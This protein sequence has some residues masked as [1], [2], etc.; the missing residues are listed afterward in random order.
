M[1]R[2]RDATLG[3][4]FG[5]SNS[6]MA[7]RQGS[8]RAR[9]LALEGT[10]TGLPTALFFNTEDQRTHFGRDAIEQYLSGT[11][12]RLMRSLK[13][14]LGSALLQDKTVVHHSA[15][16]YQDIIALF[17]QMLA[18][19]A[20]SALGGL[21]ER[22]LLGRPVHFVDDNPERDQ[23]AQ[24]AL[25]QAAHDAG[26]GEVSFQ[27]EPIAAALDYEQRISQESLVL[28][29]DIGG[30]TSDFTVVR[31]GPQRAG[32]ADR[33]GDV[34]ATTGVHIGGTD[35]DRK[36]SQARVMPLLGLGH[37]G[38]H[39]REVPSKVFH[40]LS[41]WHLIQWLY[42]PQA[43]REAQALRSDYRQPALHARLMAVLQQRLG[44]RVAEAVEQAK[45]GVSAQGHAAPVRLEWLEPNL[46]AL[47]SPDEMEHDLQALLAQVVACARACLQLAGVPAQGRGVDAIY[48]TG[49]SSAL[50][51]LRRALALAFPDTPQVEGDL[52]GGV[53]SGLACA[54]D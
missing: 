49:G 25:Q 22:V 41:T 52:F 7:V 5:T 30:G 13:S 40:D 44:H 9:L 11:E 36:L 29:V 24:A 18:Q 37:I 43:L 8:G 16:S 15:V 48:L 10:A 26:F 34:L 1:T 2:L 32:K 53:A 39:G 21:P 12:G 31:L 35:F 3:I 28:V 46:Q 19:Q 6:A 47:L 38:P 51:S 50:R 54:G 27:L 42:A 45:I 17:L 23:Q 14:L 33:S 20:C 4:D